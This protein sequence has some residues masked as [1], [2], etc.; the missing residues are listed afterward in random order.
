MERSWLVVFLLACST[1]SGGDKSS[2][3]DRYV[4]RELECN[5][6]HIKTA[7]DRQLIESMSRT[8]CMAADKVRT[9]SGDKLRAELRCLETTTECGAYEAC[10]DKTP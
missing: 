2:I 3:C 4:A 10:K 7:Q 5:A 1:S 6:S 8:L 9:A